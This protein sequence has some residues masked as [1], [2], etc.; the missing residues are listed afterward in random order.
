M[1]KTFEELISFF[2]QPGHYTK[3]EDIEEFMG[4]KQSGMFSI[5]SL[6][7]YQDFDEIFPQNIKD[8][9]EGDEFHHPFK[10]YYKRKSATSFRPDPEQINL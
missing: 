2:H 1:Y 3:T 5:L 4:N 6:I 8:I 10:Q 7:C 9:L